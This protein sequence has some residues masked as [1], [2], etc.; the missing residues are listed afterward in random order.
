MS[1]RL[2]VLLTLLAMVAFAG[3]SVLTRLALVDGVIGVVPFTAIRILSGAVVL[4][5]LVGARQ[6]VSSGS[7]RGATALLGYAVLFTL[8]YLQLDTGMGALLLFA[9]VQIAMIGWGVTTGERL[10]GLQTLGVALALVGLVWLLLPGQARPELISAGLMI[11]SGLCWGVYSLLGRAA[12]DP[13]QMTAG[14]FA[15][16]TVLGV[17]VLGL[18]LLLNTNMSAS[19]YGVGLAILSGA[20]TSGLGYAVWYR[21]LKG[22]SATR[23]GVVQLSVP[24]LA[25]LGGILLLSEPLTVRFIGASAIILVGIAL[26]ILGRS[27]YVNSK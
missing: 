24:P 12:G 7:W 13:S 10:G 11:G 2:T 4:V 8:A 25:A 17:P 18:A 5:I 27:A 3:N 21:A 23:A 26:A 15:R 16:A 19:A 20:V 9:S 22:L 6:A 14:N 1:F